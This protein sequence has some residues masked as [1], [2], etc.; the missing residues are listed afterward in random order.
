MG[1]KLL[2]NFRERPNCCDF[3]NAKRVLRRLQHTKY[4]RLF[5]SSTSKSTLVGKTDANWNGG[6]NDRR[7]TTRYYFK[8]RDSG[9]SVIWQVKKQPTVSRS[10]CEAEFQGLANAVQEAIL[11]GFPRELGYEQCELTTIGEDNQNCINLATNPVL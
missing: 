6:V 7:S 8:L 9:G 1:P 2:I 11:R 5:L 10:S 3:K 4:L